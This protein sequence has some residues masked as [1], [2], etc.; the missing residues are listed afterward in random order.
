[1]S[2]NDKDT[3][4]LIAS[5]FHVGEEVRVRV[6]CE[7][8]IVLGCG[9]RHIGRGGFTHKLAGVYV[10]FTKI[11]VAPKIHSEKPEYEIPAEHL[12]RIHFSD[13][14]GVQYFDQLPK[15]QDLNIRIGDLPDTPFWVGDVVRLRGDERPRESQTPYVVD[16]IS[17]DAP[18][19][20]GG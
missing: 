20:V 13:P 18:G 2:Q 16:S 8:V 7:Q 3:N 19:M 11:I 15:M 6:S 10:D 9:K 12:E 17:Y 5:W 4:A 14:A 1:M